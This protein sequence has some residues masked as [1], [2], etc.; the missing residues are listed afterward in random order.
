MLKSEKIAFSYFSNTIETS[1]RKPLQRLSID[2]RKP[3]AKTA[4]GLPVDVHRVLQIRS[5]IRSLNLYS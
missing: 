4:T 3:T 2:S 5:Q 1:Q